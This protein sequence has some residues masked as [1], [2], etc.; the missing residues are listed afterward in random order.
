MEFAGNRINDDTQSWE[1]MKDGTVRFL[2]TR[3]AIDVS[4]DYERE[5]D[6]ICTKGSVPGRLK[7]VAFDGQTMAW[8]S[9][10]HRPGI[11]HVVKVE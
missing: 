10:H 11:T 5:A 2:R 6:I 8:E 4:A 9:L 7:I 1:F 3:P